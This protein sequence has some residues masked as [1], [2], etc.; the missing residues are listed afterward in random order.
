MWKIMKSLFFLFLVFNFYQAKADIISDCL[1]SVSPH[2]LKE[3][4]ACDVAKTDFTACDNK[5]SVH[6]S[7]ACVRNLSS[8]YR[9]K[10]SQCKN[11]LEQVEKLCSSWVTDQKIKRLDDKNKELFQ[12]VKSLIYK[13]QEKAASINQENLLLDNKVFEQFK[14]FSQMVY[15]RLIFQYPRVYKQV[16]AKITEFEEMSSQE[17]T[18]ENA[19]RNL[20]KFKL[21]L[22]RIKNR[23]V[24][25]SIDIYYRDKEN[26][27]K[28]ILE[29]NSGKIGLA[30]VNSLNNYNE[31][32]K[33]FEKL[34]LQLAQ[35]NTTIEKK[36]GDL[37]NVEEKVTK[38]AIYLAKIQEHRN[39][40]L[41]NPNSKV[42][43][44]QLNLLQKMCN[45]ASN[46]SHH[47]YKDDQL[48]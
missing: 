11:K 23:F 33:S 10:Q 43:K 17:L 26:T 27:T 22:I 46:G 5:R 12:K 34:D 45:I 44:V 35:L 4:Q 18:K 25:N 20:K 28:N 3:I 1:S 13:E 16:Q 9:Y 7:M 41:E 37:E 39:K 31:L 24:T 42:D 14:K 32:I 6:E 30:M 38:L 8:L 15:K 40:L 2:L 36:I 29:I 19:V 48:W 47:C 21:D